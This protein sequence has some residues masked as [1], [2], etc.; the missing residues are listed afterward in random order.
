MADAEPHRHL[1]AT[2]P[3]PIVESS[4]ES[5][6]LTT[7]PATVDYTS[8]ISCFP[9]IQALWLNYIIQIGARSQYLVL[10][11]SLVQAG[12]AAVDY[13]CKSSSSKRVLRPPIK[14]PLLCLAYVLIVPSAQR[15]VLG[16]WA[17]WALTA[18]ESDFL[19]ARISDTNTFVFTTKSSTVRRVWINN[20]I[21]PV[22]ISFFQLTVTQLLEERL[23]WWFLECATKRIKSTR[24]LGAFCF[25]WH[26]HGPKM[27]HDGSW[28]WL[29]LNRNG[30][31]FIR[32]EDPLILPWLAAPRHVCTIPNRLY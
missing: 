18:A 32:I 31:L 7:R 14:C 13:T 23:I 30:D 19:A 24:S 12:P 29:S 10:S 5:K 15:I 27:H 11:E 6:L 2:V 26:Q 28:Y 4:A 20:H 17:R 1:S 21:V 3:S 22:V 16:P 25:L 8:S 9:G